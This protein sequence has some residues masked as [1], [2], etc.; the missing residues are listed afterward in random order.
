M[1]QSSHGQN[2]KN[3]KNLLCVL[4]VFSKSLEPQVEEHEIVKGVSEACV[5]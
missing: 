3:L 4:I 1:V 2:S 5:L